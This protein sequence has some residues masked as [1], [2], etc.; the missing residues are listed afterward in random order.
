MDGALRSCT[1]IGGDAIHKLAQNVVE[2]VALAGQREI[3]HQN[4]FMCYLIPGFLH[5][6]AGDCWSRTLRSYIATRVCSIVLLLFVV[7]FL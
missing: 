5:F 6:D 3:G 4:T 1:Q 7:L 2:S